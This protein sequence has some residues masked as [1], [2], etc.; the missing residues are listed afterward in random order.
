MRDAQRPPSS[1][2]VTPLKVLVCGASGFLGRAICTRLSRAGHQVIRGV[3]QARRPDDMAIDFR[4]DT[5][6]DHWRGR[7]D[8][9]Q[10][11]V[12]AVGIIAETRNSPFDALHHRGPAALFAACVKAGVA[13]IIQISALGA[14]TGSSAYFRSKHAADQALMRLPIASQILRPSL[15]HGSDGAS[16]TL[17]RQLASLP[18]LPVPA[19][20]SA[21]F[22]PVQVDDVAE[23]VLRAMDPHQP[24]GQQIDVVGAT[25]VSFGRM[26]A[27]YRH[28]MGLAPTRP[29]PVP[30]PVMAL[31]A[32]LG[33]AIP[34]VPLNPDTWRML[35]A[36]NTGDPTALTR[37]L[38]RPP[39]G[40]A[41]FIPPAQAE[42]LRGRALAAWRTPLLR[43][44][45]AFVWLATAWVSLAVHPRDA[46]LALLAG[47][48]LEGAG[49]VAALHAAVVLDLVMGL[50]CLFRPSRHLW[51]LQAALVLGYT[52]I[53]ALTL[54]TFLSHPFGPVLKNLP[55]LAILLILMSEPQPWTT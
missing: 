41:G 53:I 1:R 34:G 52:A 26:L 8:G 2:P 47:V 23:A 51:C 40:I 32:R 39:R 31:A 17:L 28:G 11:V 20:G 48:G 18:L 22:Q 45:L 43:Y 36:G 14:D 42:T 12:N 16:A 27:H 9:I 4:T 33:G 13:R 24:A 38:G 21:R 30:A 44:T 37:L 54:P 5:T 29:L 15:V 19:L 7:L 55:I 49:A 6:V 50:A 35:Q 46:S 25:R 3:R 10:V